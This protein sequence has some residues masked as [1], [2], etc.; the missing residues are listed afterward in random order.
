MNFEDVAAAAGKLQDG[1]TPVTIDTD[2]QK[3]IE[4]IQ[5]LRQDATTARQQRKF[6]VTLKYLKELSGLH[7]A[8]SP[9]ATDTEQQMAALDTEGR[10]RYERLDRRLEG[11]ILFHDAE[12][13]A[14]CRREALDLK[15]EYEGADVGGAADKLAEKAAS[16]LEKDRQVAMERMAAP[17]LRKADD[18]L[19][20]KSADGRPEP[21]KT[22]AKAFYNDIVQRFPGTEA[23][24][25]AREKLAGL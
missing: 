10:E 7:P 23:E 15:T 4:K 21:W 22:L 1:G 19:R 14:Q 5:T 16:A 6:G 9:E 25:K 24:K 18:F 2:S 13:L 17:L 11:A 20:H 3:L 8:G 12:D